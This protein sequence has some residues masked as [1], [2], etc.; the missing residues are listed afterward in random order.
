MEIRTVWME[1]NRVV[2]MIDQRKLPHRF[3][4]FES[5][6]HKTTAFAIKEMIVRG[7]G[8]IGVVAAFAVAQAANTIRTSNF[9]EFMKELNNRLDVVRASR[10]T[11]VSLFYNINRV[12]SAVRKC[13]NVDEAKDVAYD[14]AQRI[15]EES[16]EICRKIGE[17]GAELIN[18]GDTVLTH[19]NAGALA[20]V[21]WGT[22]LAPIR[23]AHYQG[24]EIK[25]L[26]DET[27]PWLQG[28]RLTAWELEMEGIEHYIISDGAAGYFMR[29]GFIRSVFVGADRI[30]ANGDVANKIGTYS[31]A[32]LAKT[33][34]VNFYVAAPLETFDLNCPNGDNIPIEERSE[35]E[36]FYVW[37]L[38]DEGAW[39]RVRIAPFGSRA[40]NPVFDV[41]PHEYVTLF[42]TEKGL[43]KP[44]FKENIQL[45]IRGGSHK[46]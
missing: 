35:D 23:M 3:E 46:K 38:D 26:V 14:E 18:D 45:L 5:P 13:G 43:V 21:D 6:D 42:I 11:A 16:V 4:I 31:L 8:A 37:G 2:K 44:P 33:N 41:T 29:K 9:E 27:R 1:E 39:R 22:A 20:F 19:C 40:H 25:V 32:I 30:A 34:N 17:F 12:L 10:P 28:A 15:A 24:K 7:A 36:I